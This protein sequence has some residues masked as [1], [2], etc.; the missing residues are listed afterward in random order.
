MPKQAP[1][2]PIK[3]VRAARRWTQERAAQELGVVK[4]TVSNWERGKRPTR[5]EHLIKLRDVM[6]ID[7]AII[8]AFYFE[9]L[10][11]HAPSPRRRGA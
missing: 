2:N 6:G 8:T 3:Q 11:R 4:M 7:P 9:S 10:A 1:V 5:S